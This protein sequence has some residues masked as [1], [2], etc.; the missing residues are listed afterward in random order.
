MKY[1]KTPASCV[2]IWKKKCIVIIIMEREI[3]Y[4]C[5]KCNEGFTYKD[6]YDRHM[7]RKTPCNKEEKQ[8]KEIKKRTCIYC[9][10]IYARADVL[11][12]H[13]AKCKTKHV[14]ENDT[15][16][17]IHQ[18]LEIM[19]EEM[20]KEM[21]EKMAHHVLKISEV[22]D[23]KIDE[24]MKR[25]TYLESNQK[26][27]KTTVKGKKS[28]VVNGNVNNTNTNNTTNNIQQNIHN[29]IKIVAYGKEDLSYITDE[30]YALLINKGFKSVPNFIEYIHFNKNKPEHQN[31]Y[32]SNMRD[33][34]L[35]IF[36]GE[37]WQ[38]KER[39]DVLQEMIENKTDILN[40]KFDELLKIL[41]ESTIKKFSNFLNEKD[42]DRIIE[43]I[44]KDLK[45][46]LYNRKQ[47]SD[48]KPRI[49]GA[50]VANKT[51]T[52]KDNNNESIDAIIQESK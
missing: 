33:T 27:T 17:N 22:K 34:H 4:T 45:L 10:K 38:L 52:A 37:N 5:N 32:I 39:D 40:D 3:K 46:I 20:K 18:M 36:D 51:I 21:E 6:K 49:G 48:I 42:E 29:E 9:N 12:E 1:V 13:I 43:Q 8:Q 26:S 15:K 16:G 24:L 25:I 19:K 23:A 11:K 28:T 47:I 30:N 44:K 35:L 50:N 2:K 7:M 14:N 31:I 41:D